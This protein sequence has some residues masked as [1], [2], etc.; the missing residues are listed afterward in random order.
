M[1]MMM[2]GK[3]K[4]ECTKCSMAQ[5]TDMLGNQ[6]DKPVVD[7]TGLAGNFQFTLIFLPEFRNMPMP[8][9]AGRGPAPTGPGGAATP[10]APEDNAPALLAALPDQL[11]LK[12]EAKK[13]P[14]DLVVIDH[15][16]KTPTEN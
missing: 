13:A 6:L 5:L 7:M 4:M 9:M 8:M 1:I 10:D 2:P 14:I 15:L 16:E 3:A 11:G 12:L